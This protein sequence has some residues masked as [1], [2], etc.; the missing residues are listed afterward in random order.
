MNA[1]SLLTER[2]IS[3]P[4]AELEIKN[5]YVESNK[6]QLPRKNSENFN[7]KLRDTL[8]EGNSAR[9]RTDRSKYITIAETDSK[10]LKISKR[11][12]YKRRWHMRAKP[13]AIFYFTGVIGRYINYNTIG[14][15][16]KTN[17]YF[18]KNIAKYLI[19]LRQS[20]QIVLV[21]TYSTKRTLSLQDHFCK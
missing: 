2:G 14:F 20:F 13:L 8:M 19:T 1:E 15:V 10:Y 21:T 5:L 17:L 18:R 7:R 4:G 3:N 6:L 16:S 9:L 12:F 11:I